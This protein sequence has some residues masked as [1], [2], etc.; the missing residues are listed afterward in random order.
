[1]LFVVVVVAA[2]FV[3]VAAFVVAAVVAA[4]AAAAAPTHPHFAATA[5]PARGAGWA[6]CAAVLGSFLVLEVLALCVLARRHR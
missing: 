3:V 5:H 4:A 6:C 2:A 1:M